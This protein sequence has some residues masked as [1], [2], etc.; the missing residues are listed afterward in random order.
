[1]RRIAEIGAI[2][3]TA[4]LNHPLDDLDLVPIRGRAHDEPHLAAVV[5]NRSKHWAA[6]IKA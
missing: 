1:M 2:I 4:W 5:T 3:V 6:R